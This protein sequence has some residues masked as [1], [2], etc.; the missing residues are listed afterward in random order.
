MDMKEQEAIDVDITE[1]GI[2][3]NNYRRRLTG[4][5]IDIVN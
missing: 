2:D 1:F 3:F 5:L 4:N